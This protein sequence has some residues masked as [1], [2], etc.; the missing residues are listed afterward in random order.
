MEDTKL[1]A[2]WK[3]SVLLPDIENAATLSSLIPR[4]VDASVDVFFSKPNADAAVWMQ[5]AEEIVRLFGTFLEFDLPA[6]DAARAKRELA[7][8]TKRKTEMVTEIR[9]LGPKPKPSSETGGTC[10]SHHFCLSIFAF[11]VLSFFALALL[12]L[13][14]FASR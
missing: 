3:G 10:L 9:K 13:V 7:A 5:D 6:D 4:F 1:S 2:S 11:R 14:S 12:D 8:L